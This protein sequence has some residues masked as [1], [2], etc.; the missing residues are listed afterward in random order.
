MLSPT[1]LFVSFFAL[2]LLAHAASR[3]SPPSGSIVVRQNTTTTGEFKTITAAVNSLPSDG[4]KRSIFVFPGTYSEQ[5][6]I[7]RTGPLIV[8]EEIF[9]LG[10]I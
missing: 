8:S 3:T 6:F 2:P 10:A 4:S 7:N 9:P 5:V 1:C